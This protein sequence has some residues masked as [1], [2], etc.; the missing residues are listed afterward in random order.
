M[1]VVL[2]VILN[3]LTAALNAHNVVIITLKLAM[4]L[5]GLVVTSVIHSNDQWYTDDI[6]KFH[7]GQNISLK[8]A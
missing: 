2:M 5:N 6:K 7:L 1:N 4:S 8:V 3:Q